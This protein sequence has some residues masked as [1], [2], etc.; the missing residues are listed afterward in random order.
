MLKKVLLTNINSGRTTEVIVDTDDDQ[1]AILGSGKAPNETARVL[2]ITGAD[3]FVQRWTGKKPSLDEMVVLFGNLARCLERNISTIKSLELVAARLTSP[4]Y[5]GVVADVATRITAG[6]KM[7][8][9]FAAH[10]DLFPEDI[11]ALLR[12]GEESGQLSE[13]LKQVTGGRKNTLRILKKLKSGMIYPG[14]VLVLA[15]GVIIVMSF[16]L[17]PA[18]SKL[19]GSMGADLPLATVIMMKI[20]E[21]LIH[22]P[23]LAVL[24]FVGLWVFFKYWGK[25]Y[26]H[27]SVQRGLTSLPVIG[28][29]IRKSAS[30]VSFRTFAMLM[31]AN[32]RITTA[33][34]ITAKSSGHV[35]YETFF[36]RIKD[37][38]VE[39]LSLP[40]SFLM[41]SH[42]LGE[43]GR[44]V[45]A[46]VQIAG[47][48]GSINEMLDEIAA[49]YEEDLETVASQIDK[50]L[51]PFILVM[52][53][54][55]VGFIIYAIYG[56]IFNLS[57]V[58]LPQR[59]GVGSIFLQWFP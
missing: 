54:L 41:E 59:P 9:C 26:R 17:V 16:T 38:V 13:T 55:I 18:I 15:V 31:Q 34:E 39:G 42:H 51:E 52:M 57:R 21:I 20:S 7:S 8:E 29:I 2:D 12:A 36:T 50:V 32:V 3:E 48:T 24:P 25:I 44:T 19:Y 37:H 23:Y 46:V 58:L 53:G 47:E 22:Q 1:K 4:R 5:R 6:D 40:E 27:P 56:P 11:V 43:D 35:D 14:I 30:T 49:D 33:L 45:S 10:P 28:G